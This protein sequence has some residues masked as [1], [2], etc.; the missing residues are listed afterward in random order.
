MAVEGGAWV[1]VGVPA[2]KFKILK[3]LVELISRNAFA[4]LLVLFKRTSKLVYLN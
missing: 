1:P 4:L 3:N 2:Q